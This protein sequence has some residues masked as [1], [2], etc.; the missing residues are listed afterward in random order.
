MNKP[1]VS[2]I[3]QDFYPM[4]GG[5]ASYIMQIYT[6]YLS[7]AYVDIILPNQVGKGTAYDKFGFKVHTT[8]F[9]PF[10]SQDERQNENK[11][12][13]EILTQCNPDIILFG[14]LR[15][16]PETGLMYKANHPE[17][18]I[19]ILTHAKEIILDKSITTTNHTLSGAHT[20]YLNSEIKAYK[21]ILNS[22][23]KI[24]A[25]SKYTANLLKKQGVNREIN[26]LY[27]S[28]DTTS[29]ANR[30][31]KEQLGYEE[32]DLL[33]LTVGRLIER[34]GQSKVI[35]AV[36]NIIP[37]FQ[38]LKYAIIGNGPERNNLENMILSKNLSNNITIL[39][40]ISDKMLS[41]YYSACDLFA[42]PNNFNLPNDV[43]GF[44]IVFLEANL[45]KKPVIAGYSGGVIEAVQNKKTG[46]L[47]NPNNP[48]EL[49]K[50]IIML[51]KNRELRDKLGKNG[52]ERVIKKFNNLP[53]N[54]LLNIFK[55]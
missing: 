17:C 20:G 9:N 30:C 41:D 42:L 8:K 33:I 29:Y 2:I 54:N 6:K 16:H 3:T 10:V 46:L 34:K 11:A 31:T 47:I 26:I 28:I 25:V 7:N 45:Y 23:D 38:N 43:E 40:N 39:D 53:S 13:L 12:I 48:S 35:Q 14:Y 44:G 52:Q 51:L 4:R 49:E 22:F 37:D 1:R 24:F 50:S 15:S 27:P 18:K 21:N 5:I 32:N 36:S 55:G 19:G